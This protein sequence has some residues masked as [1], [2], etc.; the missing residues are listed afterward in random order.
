MDLI[1]LSVVPYRVL[2]LLCGGGRAGGGGRGPKT[3]ARVGL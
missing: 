1:V 3:D 2:S